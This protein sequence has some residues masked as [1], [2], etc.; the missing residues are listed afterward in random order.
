M[1]TL[2][3]E[4]PKMFKNQPLLF[5]LSILL[6]PA[7]GLGILILLIW[8]LSTKASKLELDESRI[9]H[10]KGLLSKERRE[11]SMSSVRTV[12]TQQSFT[13]RIF[14][15]GTVEVYS[16]GDVPEIVISGIPNPNHIRELVMDRQRDANTRT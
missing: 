12:R 9:K 6:I 1:S 13:D 16:A 15:V 3:S 10:E 14:G 5:I 8:Y 4:H 2:Y 11:L 7:F